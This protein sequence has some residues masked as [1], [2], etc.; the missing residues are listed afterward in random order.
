MSF[1]LFFVLSKRVL[2]GLSTPSG[3]YRLKHD[4]QSPPSRTVS[5]LNPLC[6]PSPT[7]IRFLSHRQTDVHGASLFLI[8]F[9]SLVSI[10][11]QDTR[12]HGAYTVR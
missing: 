11:L 2:R 12:T 4:K 5:P 6:P 8:L 10:A 3:S 9:L 1:F 7:F